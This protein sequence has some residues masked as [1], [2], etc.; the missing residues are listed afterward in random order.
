MVVE[1]LD[2]KKRPILHI[3]GYL[4]YFSEE[5]K[6]RINWKCKEYPECKA[7]AVTMAQMADREVCKK[8]K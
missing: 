4:Y 3:D 8:K 2:G 6:G 5:K 1:L 7:R